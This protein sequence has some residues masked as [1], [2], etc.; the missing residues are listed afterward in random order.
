MRH[1]IKQRNSHRGEN[2]AGNKKGKQEHE[3]LFTI[4]L[5]PFFLKKQYLT[6]KTE[7]VSSF[8]SLLFAFP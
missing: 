5:L 1:K 8:I 4:I 3:H 6:L 7:M 2:E